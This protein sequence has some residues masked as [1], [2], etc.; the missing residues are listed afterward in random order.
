MSVQLFGYC[1]FVLW[2]LVFKRIIIGYRIISFNFLT[3]VASRGFHI[4]KNITWENVNIG[5]EISVQLETNED[6]K[7]I[8]PY[9]CAIKTM[10]SGKLVTV[11]HI[12][13]GFQ[14]IP[15]FISKKKKDA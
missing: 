8:D 7:K 9:C 1:F 13:R 2:V 14:G 6:S 15:T 5:Q 10:V 3:K 11:G 12:P 4:Y